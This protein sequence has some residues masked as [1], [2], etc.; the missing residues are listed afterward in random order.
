VGYVNVQSPKTTLTDL[1]VQPGET[2]KA[3]YKITIPSDYQGVST[4]GKYRFTV[5]VYVWDKKI[6][7]FQKEVEVK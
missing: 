4:A 7:N 6:G 2:K 5:D 1:G 3:E